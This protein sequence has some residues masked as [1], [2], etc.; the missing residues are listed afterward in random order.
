MLENVTGTVHISIK[1]KKFF[2]FLNKKKTCR[3]GHTHIRF[4]AGHR[5]EFLE[6]PSYRYRLWHR[7]TPNADFELIRLQNAATL[8]CCFAF[9]TRDSLQNTFKSVYWCMDLPPYTFLFKL[10][11]YKW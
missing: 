10:L 8:Q 7:V 2:F 1:K 3:L 9:D 11:L 6:H 5:Y 4:K